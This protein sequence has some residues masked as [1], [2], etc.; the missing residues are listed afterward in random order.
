MSHFKDKLKLYNF[1]KVRNICLVFSKTAQSGTIVLM[2]DN[3][4]E[5]SV[6]LHPNT[7]PQQP[8]AQPAPV[9]VPTPP[10]QPLPPTSQ[11]APTPP[12]VVTTQPP[13]VTEPTKAPDL[14]QERTTPFR[15]EEDSHVSNEREPLEP[16]TWTASEYIAHKK[17]LSWY[18]IL[19]AGAAV[20]T[21][22]IYFITGGDLF[23]S[24]SVLTLAIV[25]GLYAGRQPREQN[26]ALDNDGVHIGSRTYSFDV[27]KSF[28]VLDEGPFSS[29][30]FMPM[31]RFMP[32]I[33][34]YYD[35]A[36]EEKIVAYLSAIMPM[37][38]RKH[39][40]I[41]RLMHKIKF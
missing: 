38:Y 18:L 16:V 2:Q 9:V 7:A 40:N 39:D 32:L 37:E 25:F 35:P 19:G 41:E 11:V 22:L 1:N 33:S 6:S 26:Y 17:N 8:V 36:D 27:L 13:A 30:V 20:L 4:K 24:L 14:H 31:K 12:P 5:E 10:V 34:I 23:S 29:V 3:T 28:S 15:A 21:V